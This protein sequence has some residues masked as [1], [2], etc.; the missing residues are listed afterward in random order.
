VITA[1]FDDIVFQV[2]AVKRRLA[3]TSA[4]QQQQQPFYNH[5][6]Q[7]KPGVSIPEE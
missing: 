2:L 1:Q 3:C 7:D 6:T 4:K 5:F